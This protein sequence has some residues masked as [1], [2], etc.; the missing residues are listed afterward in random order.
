M[1]RSTYVKT[2]L[3]EGLTEEELTYLF[4]DEEIVPY[5]TEPNVLTLTTSAVLV[6]HLPTNAAIA[7][8][9]Y[10]EYYRTLPAGQ[11][12]DRSKLVVAKESYAL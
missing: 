10:N 2:Q 7:G 6:N 5:D 12:P 9:P 1:H 4:P 11:A 3:G 8:D